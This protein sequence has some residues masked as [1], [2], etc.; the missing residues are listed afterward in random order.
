MID[1]YL[2]ILLKPRVEITML[3]QMIVA[4]PICLIVL[5]ICIIFWLKEK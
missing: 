2:E 1:L 3:D 5:A 4:L